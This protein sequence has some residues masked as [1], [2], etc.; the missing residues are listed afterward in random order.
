MS[1]QHSHTFT[2]PLVRRFEYL[3]GTRPSTLVSSFTQDINFQAN[4]HSHYYTLHY[5]TFPTA[6]MCIINV[7][8]KKCGTCY[9]KIKETHAAPKQ[10][11]SYK[12][13]KGCSG[14]TYPENF[15]WLLKTHCPK[16][17]END[18]K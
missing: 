10:C 9:H 16:C 3:K 17:K 13:G 15:K 14:I 11:E 4:Q 2:R 1:K 18:K 7:E 5:T 8:I 12:D 6:N